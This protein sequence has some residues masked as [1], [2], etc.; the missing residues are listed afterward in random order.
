M[1]A[2][3]LLVPLLFGVLVATGASAQD[4]AAPAP[5]PPSDVRPDVPA[6]PESVVLFDATPVDYVET[7]PEESARDGDLL[8]KHGQIVERTV[9]LPAAPES[10]REARRIMLRVKVEPVIDAARRP[11][12][13][14][15]RLGALSLVEPG[16]VG[17]PSREVEI[18]RFITG[19]G[20]TCVFE[21]DVT[22]LAPLL[23]GRRTVRILLST[24]MSPAYRITATLHYDAAG[25]G[26]RRPAF[27]AP[28]LME[29][30][31]TSETGPMLATVTVPEHITQFRLRILSTGHATDGQLGDEFVTRPH[32]VLLD[33][34]EIA[35]FRPWSERGGPNRH[36]NPTSGRTAI[37]GREIWSS[38]FDRSGWTPGLVVEPLIIP[39][40]ELTP[41]E[42]TITLR[43]DGIRAPTEAAPGRGYW[44]SSVILVG[45]EPWPEAAGE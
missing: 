1:T 29:E 39:L 6:A 26:A 41:G 45:D 3:R 32:V 43:I 44:R 25:I 19:F 31:V 4:D 22:P 24:Y 27:A 10:Q 13:L 7:R 12:D 15:T 23:H 35:R 17:S 11:S 9:E 16:P 30:M 14:W 36:L 34:R 38:D 40:L 18:M 2:A 37:D 5:P 8:R 28:L 21:Q 33:G 20:G 42:H